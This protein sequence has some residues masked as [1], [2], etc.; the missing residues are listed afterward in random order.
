MTIRRRT[1]KARSW[2]KYSLGTKVQKIRRIYFWVFFWNGTRQSRVWTHSRFG[3]ALTPSS[4]LTAVPP[5]P[6]TSSLY[7]LPGSSAGSGLGTSGRLEVE[8]EER[9]RTTG[10]K[11]STGSRPV[12]PSPGFSSC[13][14]PADCHFV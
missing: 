3:L 7:N 1:K 10:A 4:L 8:V 14:K 13:H 2:Q 11:A 12:D 9:G 6:P 5:P